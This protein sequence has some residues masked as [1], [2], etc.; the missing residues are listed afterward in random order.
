MST[1]AAATAAAA[2]W[3]RP[4][5]MTMAGG[6]ATTIV[7]RDTLPD[8]DLMHGCHRVWTATKAFVPMY[9]DYLRH[10]RRCSGHEDDVG[11]C[12]ESRQVLWR[13]V[14]ERLRDLC[15]CVS[16]VFLWLFLAKEGDH[17]NSN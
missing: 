1:T 8:S 13:E 7:F 5:L 14:A 11:F 4:V 10:T 12:W 9:V 6:A 17:P 2:M 15:R 3:R 16:G